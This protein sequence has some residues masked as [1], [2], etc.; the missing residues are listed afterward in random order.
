MHEEQTFTE[1]ILKKFL[2]PFLIVLI[3]VFALFQHIFVGRGI[4]INPPKII[5]FEKGSSIQS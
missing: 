4:E 5:A 3:S 2:L 1:K